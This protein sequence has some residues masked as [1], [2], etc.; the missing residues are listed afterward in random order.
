VHRNEELVVI[1]AGRYVFDI[2]GKEH[3]VGTGDSL[4][5]SGGIPHRYRLVGSPPHRFLAVIVHDD[6][7]VIPRAVPP[8]GPGAVLTTHCGHLE[9][10]PRR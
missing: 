6:F 4:A 5:Y 3:E 2:A 10:P 7:D 1:L 9:P 8:A